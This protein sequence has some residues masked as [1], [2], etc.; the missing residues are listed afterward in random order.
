MREAYWGY[1]L[2]V[3]GVFVIVVLLLVQSFTSTTSQDYYLVKDIAEA[4]MLDAVDYGY[5]MISIDKLNSSDTKFTVE[6]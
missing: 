3:L 6:E 1:W 4:S 5:R 2:I